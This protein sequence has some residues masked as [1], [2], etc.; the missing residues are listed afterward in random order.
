[1]KILFKGKF[2]YLSMLLFT[3]SLLILYLSNEVITLL[4]TILYCMCIHMY[5][6]MHV[7]VYV[8]MFM[9]MCVYILNVCMYVYLVYIYAFGT[10]NTCL[11][12]FC[13]VLYRPTCVKCV[14]LWLLWFQIL[15]CMWNFITNSI[16]IIISIIITHQP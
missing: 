15:D 16:I 11:F 12:L 2:I 6:C 9:Y 4:F 5:G 13:N 10:S 7:Y 3:L 14:T 8:Y 1:M